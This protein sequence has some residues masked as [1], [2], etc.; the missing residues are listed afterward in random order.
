MK[1]TDSK[2]VVI[3]TAN[4]RPIAHSKYLRRGMENENRILTDN[5]T[6]GATA[7]CQ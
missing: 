2:I 1:T 7:I 3:K 6:A 5:M 4:S